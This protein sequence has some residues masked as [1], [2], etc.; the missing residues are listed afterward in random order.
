[1]EMEKQDLRLKETPPYM[2]H[3]EL[4]EEN[5]KGP[6]VFLKHYQMCFQHP[7]TVWFYFHAQHRMF[8]IG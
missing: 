3:L 8:H 5:P 6:A 1:M 2:Q 7:P 4:R